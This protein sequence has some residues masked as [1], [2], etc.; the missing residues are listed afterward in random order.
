[1]TC[2]G[3]FTYL[4]YKLVI[5]I[6]IFA[7]LFLPAKL[8]SERVARSYTFKTWREFF[9]FSI[10]SAGDFDPDAIYLYAEYPHGSVPLGPVLGGATLPY[11]AHR[12]CIISFF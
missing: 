12:I 2:L 6:L 1:M 9:S 4:S 5:L 8:Y 7:S 3:I 11:F 10:V